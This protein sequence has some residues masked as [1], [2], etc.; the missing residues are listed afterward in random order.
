MSLRHFCK[1]A[2]IG[3]ILVSFFSC[4]NNSSKV[5]NKI[6]YIKSIGDTNP[7]LAMS[8]LDSLDINIR[9]QPERVIKKFDLLRLRVQDKA[10]ITATSDIAAKQL[11]T[12]FEKNGTALEKQEAYFYAGS[13]YRDLQDTPRALKYFFKALE[14]AENSKQFDTVMQRNTF[15]NL[16]YLYFNVQDYPKA[17]EYAMKEYK[18]SQSINKM[19]LTCLM[20]LGMSLTVL[21][22]IKQAKEIYKIA[23]DT[24]SSNPQLKEDHEVLCSLLFNF[25]YLKDSV[26]ASRCYKLLQDQNLDDS[27]DAKNYAYGEFFLLVGKKETA[28]CAFNR[29]LHNKTDLLRMYDASKALFHIYNEGK[30]VVE[31]NKMA[32]LFVSL[33]DSIDLGKRQELAATVKNEYQ[34]HK[35]Q[36]REQKIINE[37]ERLQSWLIISVAAIVII[38]LIAVAFIFYKRY[39][40]LNRLLAISNDLNDLNDLSV[41]KQQLQTNIKKKEEELLA[42]QSLL[43]KRENELKSVKNQL[44]DLNGEL[45]KFDEK[46]KEK[47]QMLSEKIA[48]SQT[49]LNLLHQTELEEKAEDVIFNIRQSSEGK[50]HMT[51]TN[52]K[53]LYKAVDELYPA[54]KDQLMKELGSF[55]EQQMQVCY[56]MRIGLSKP[57]IQNIT[58]LSRVTIW[59]WVKKFN[60]I[61]TTGLSN[62]KDANTQ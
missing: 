36:Q 52:W 23:L 22:S 47:E 10:Y 46:L 43:D 40:Y 35:D 48:Q 29:I 34:Y 55:S 39:T 32:N 9:N 41:A 57:Q 11:V 4:D 5:S 54:F 16:H 42:S 59:R 37:K 50:K 13:V 3:L 56:L 49:F 45:T 60:W 53:Q 31:A 7:S 2:A 20:H 17:Y 62:N 18:L 58:N 44:K 19:E 15:S 28:I 51:N 33:C 27:N 8:M 38:L 30:Q 14:I 61:Q 25:S 1:I 24:I 26:Q 6:D 12:Y 21:D